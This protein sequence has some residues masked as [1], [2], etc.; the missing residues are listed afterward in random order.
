MLAYLAAMRRTSLCMLAL[1]V[2]CS[3]DPT[4]DTGGAEA[5]GDD[6]GTADSGDDGGND[7]GE[8]GTDDGGSGMQGLA[9]K[10]G[11]ATVLSGSF[12]GLEDRYLIGDEGNG[13]DICRISTTL[14]STA[15]RTDCDDCAWA[16]DLTVSN[17]AVAAESGP[18]CPTDGSEL[19][20]TTIS[21][22]YIP[23]YLGHANVLAVDTGN[24]WAPVDNAT[25]DAKS[26]FFTYDW[27]DGYVSY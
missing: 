4:D 6:G 21:Y 18:G 25:Y 14:T 17:A 24:G 12:S 2:A 10:A 19:N 9:G 22:G 16:F 8:A 23:E 27:Q 7:G 13:V 11:D 3:G 1:L 5:G 20:G 26:G 15:E